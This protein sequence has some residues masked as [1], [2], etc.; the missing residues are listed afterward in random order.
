[1][2]LTTCRFELADGIAMVQT[3]AF[4]NWA[5]ANPDAAKK[6]VAIRADLANEGVYFVSKNLTQFSDV[7]RIITRVKLV[8]PPQGSGAAQTFENMKKVLPNVFTRIETA[9]IRRATRPSSEYSGSMPLEKKKL[10]FGAK[11][12]TER[13]RAR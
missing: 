7:V 11:S 3:D 8:L 4:A 9:Q 1:M 5:A 2:E 6:L 10:R 13:P 12:S